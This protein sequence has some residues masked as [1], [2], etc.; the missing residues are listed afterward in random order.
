MARS[1]LCLNCAVR[2]SVATD[3]RLYWQRGARRA[4]PPAFLT[5]AYRVHAFPR[6]MIPSCLDPPTPR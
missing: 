5:Q 2:R 6:G 3:D 4:P 1:A